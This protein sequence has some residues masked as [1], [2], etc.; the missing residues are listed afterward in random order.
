M[1]DDWQVGDLAVCFMARDQIIEPSD[2]S[3]RLVVGTI[4]VVT[5]LDCSVTP[6]GLYLLGMQAVKTG[7]FSDSYDSSCFR[8]IRP[9]SEP[10]EEEFV[11]L[12][13][14]MKPAKVSS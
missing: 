8:K 2:P 7:K 11:T 12:I 3:D 10:C 5:G 1:S 13:K 9:D 6:L 14:R 4:Y